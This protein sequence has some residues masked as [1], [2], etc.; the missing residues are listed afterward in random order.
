MLD[1]QDTPLARRCRAFWPLLAGWGLAVPLL[2]LPA[3]AQAQATV[4]AEGGLATY[5]KALRWLPVQMTLTNQG[6][7][8]RVQ[9]RA[10]FSGHQEG[11]QEHTLPERDLPSN[12]NQVH[13]FYIK[14]PQ[15][16][17]GQPLTVELYRDGQVINK[18]QPTL[19]QVGEADWLIAGVGP[20]ELRS[21][22]QLLNGTTIQG[23]FSPRGRP[24]GGNPQ[25]R[26]YWAGVEPEK[27]PDRWQGF[28]AVDLLVLGNLSDR[29]LTPDQLTAI[30]DYVVAGGTLVVTGGINSSR[31]ATPFFRD[32]LR[33][34]VSGTRTA[35]SLPSLAGFSSRLA[36][37][38]GSI[39]VTTCQPKAGAQVELEEGGQPLLVS[40][41][42]GSGRVLF[43]AFDPAVPPFAGNQGLVDLFKQLMVRAPAAGLITMVNAAEAQNENYPGNFNGY[44]NRTRLADAPYAIPQ[45][46]IPAF[47][48]VAL[49]LLAYI[50]VLVPV[51][52]FVLK[53][54]DKKEYAWLTTPAIVAVFSIGAYLIGYGFKGGRTLLVR[55]GVIEA[56]AGQDAAPNVLYAGL[57][58]PSKTGYELQ[59]ASRTKEEQEQSSSVLLSEPAHV[60]SSAG[61]KVVQDDVRKIRDFAVDMWAMRVVKSEGITRLGNGI[62]AQYR[63]E[64]SRL[65]GT[66]TN[67]SPYPLEDCHVVDRGQMVR[68]ENLEP[69]KSVQFDLAP[70]QTY[71]GGGLLPTSLLNEVHGSREQQRMKTAILQSLLVQG[72]VPAAGPP[73]PALVGW[74]REDAPVARILVNDRTPRELAATLMVVHLGS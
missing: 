5:Y 42:K 32:L 56:R 51:N 8:A 46:D 20:S 47:Y 66:L 7:P 62:T 33:V 61:L 67:N 21:G 65:V 19:I 9:V 43:L 4:T 29:E 30:R 58:S 27:A 36:D 14:P 39:P 25:A 70:K 1:S 55:V 53:A 45:L 3:R 24:W 44:G 48:I 40:G 71:P 10:R 73:Q 49:F 74:V 11:P 23:Q 41:P 22:L 34:Q 13:T 16:Y 15:I 35:S 31:L 69:G 72:A 52:Y 54:K 2:F 60:R 38:R 18:S 59:L 12:A 50:V 17:S 26:V 64:G 37:V 63:R 57:F 68:V 28:D 6:Q